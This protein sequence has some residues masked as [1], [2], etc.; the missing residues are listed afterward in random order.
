M[1]FMLPRFSKHIF[2]AVFFWL[3]LYVGRPGWPLQMPWKKFA[4]QGLETRMATTAEAGALLERMAGTDGNAWHLVE[5]V[6]YGCWHHESTATFS[7]QCDMSSCIH[8]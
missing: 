1:R 6:F 8:K 5:G 2:T 7:P 4:V 3:F